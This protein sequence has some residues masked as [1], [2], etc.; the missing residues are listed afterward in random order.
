MEK[1]EIHLVP[2]S[3]FSKR[4]VWD[5]LLSK[6]IG[7]SLNGLVFKT[8]VPKENIKELSTMCQFKSMIKLTHDTSESA[9]SCHKNTS[10]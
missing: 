2:T 8:S 7:F 10:E 3:Q 9:T 4:D 5:W 1:Y 6:N